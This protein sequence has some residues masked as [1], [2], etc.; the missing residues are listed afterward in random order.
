MVNW[1]SRYYRRR[2]FRRNKIKRIPRFGYPKVVRYT[3]TF[4]NDYGLCYTLGYQKDKF[5]WYKDP[6]A[7]QKGTVEKDNPTLALRDFMDDWDAPCKGYMQEDKALKE[8]IRVYDKYKLESIVHTFSQFRFKK[9]TIKCKQDNIPLDEKNKCLYKYLQLYDS[10]VDDVT[11]VLNYDPPDSK[12]DISIE[13]LP[14]LPFQYRY[15]H[16]GNTT[17]KDLKTGIDV[18]YP[19]YDI[20]DLKTRKMHFKSFFKIVCKP[21]AKNY[22]ASE[23][24]KATSYGCKF[25]NWI[26]AMGSTVNPSLI[27]GR[28]MPPNELVA[29]DNARIPNN[30]ELYVMSYHIRL[31]YNFVFA[32]KR[33][34]VT[35]Q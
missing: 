32:G 13:D 31:H 22:L 4:N 26:R 27:R 14:S 3:H 18:V 8:L 29:V 9:I 5:V 1:R 20:P 10:Q 21:Y 7:K 17:D 30:V 28:I 24:F 23:N 15:S 11:E 12:F 2:K 16:L 35:Y 25:L 34:D 19:G 6:S 33:A